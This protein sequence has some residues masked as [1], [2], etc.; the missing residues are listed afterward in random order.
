MS[1]QPYYDNYPE[2]CTDEWFIA[3]EGELKLV[4]EHT[5]RPRPGSIGWLNAADKKLSIRENSGH[6]IGDTEWCHQ[7]HQELIGL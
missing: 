4:D 5:Q 3:I 6:P 7:V 1:R 2:P